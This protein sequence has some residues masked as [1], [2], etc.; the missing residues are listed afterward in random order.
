MKKFLS[1][2]SILVLSMLLVAC[3]LNIEDKRSGEQVTIKHE[4]SVF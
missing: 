4:V 1:V 2:I 3:N